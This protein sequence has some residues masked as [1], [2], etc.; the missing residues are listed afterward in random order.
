MADLESIRLLLAP[1]AGSTD[2]AILQLPL[3]VG[4]TFD[5]VT[6]MV[7][8]FR[9]D[10]AE[11]YELIVSHDL[12]QT[13]SGA[14]TAAI[15]L[16]IWFFWPGFTSQVGGSTDLWNLPGE[17]KR[18]AG[19]QLV[20]VLAGATGISGMF[21]TAYYREGPRLKEELWIAL[22]RRTSFRSLGR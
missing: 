1:T 15:D 14:A 10:Q 18:V 12:D 21:F 2:T 5:I 13:G 19:P 20:R 8:L 22:Q 11:T 3:V 7:Q 16:P 9:A 6:I 17:G 4:R